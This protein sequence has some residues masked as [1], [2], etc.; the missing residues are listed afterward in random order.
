M[1]QSLQCVHH[2]Q[3]E[4]TELR[5]LENILPS[6]RSSKPTFPKRRMK[7]ERIS[8][9]SSTS[10]AYEE[11]ARSFETPFHNTNT[12]QAIPACPL[13]CYLNNLPWCFQ[14]RTTG[15]QNDEIFWRTEDIWKTLGDAL[16]HGTG[17]RD[18]PSHESHLL[19]QNASV[20]KAQI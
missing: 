18:E 12:S 1:I 11:G 5:A 2:D 7:R 17:H 15:T 6:K 9:L 4:P 20:T 16:W 14:F 3:W 13:K 8:T 10:S 19:T